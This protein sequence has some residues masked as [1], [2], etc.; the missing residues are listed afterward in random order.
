MP[1]FTVE[2]SDSGVSSVYFE[3]HVFCSVHH[4]HAG[5]VEN[6][7]KRAE[8]IAELFNKEYQ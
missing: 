3:G 8:R 2:T 7:R 4:L 6:A 5:G 1:R